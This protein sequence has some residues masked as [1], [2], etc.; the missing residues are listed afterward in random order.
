MQTTV[1][2]GTSYNQ[3]RYLRDLPFFNSPIIWSFFSRVSMDRFLLVVEA[4]ETKTIKCSMEYSV[5]IAM[6]A[7]ATK[8]DA[9]PKLI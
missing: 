1:D 8:P 7:H 2:L 6:R 5:I 9:P 4:S 3:D